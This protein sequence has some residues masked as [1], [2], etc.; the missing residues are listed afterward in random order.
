MGATRKKDA[1]R[2]AREAEADESKRKHDEEKTAAGNAPPKPRKS[3]RMSKV[4]ANK[5]MTGKNIDRL[6]EDDRIKT[7]NVGV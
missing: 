2:K 4:K 7:S 6:K 3:H 5:H 1:V